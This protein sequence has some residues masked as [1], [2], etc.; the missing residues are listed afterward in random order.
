MGPLAMILAIPALFLMLV[1]LVFVSSLFI[2]IDFGARYAPLYFSAAF[3]GSICLIV[4]WIEVRFDLKR[5]GKSL[6]NNQK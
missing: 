3:W 1:P 5:A 2:V 6:F 4:S